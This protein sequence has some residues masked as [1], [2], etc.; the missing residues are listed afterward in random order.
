MAAGKSRSGAATNIQNLFSQGA[1]KRGNFA[2]KLIDENTETQLR[3][4]EQQIHRITLDLLLDNPYQPRETIAMDDELRELAESIKTHGFQGAI[5]ARK[6]PAR[7]GYYQLAY[8]HRRREAARLAGEPDLP[9]I[10]QNLSNRAMAGIAGIENIH[11]KDLTLLEQGKLFL[12]MQRE[13][14]TQQEIATMV[15]KDRG[16][17]VNRLRVA[18][19]PA[20]IQ[21]FVVAKPDSLRMVAYLMKVDEP[22]DRALL[23]DLIRAGKLK[24]DDLAGDINGLVASLSATR[25]VSSPPSALQ[26][27]Q[28]VTDESPVPSPAQRRAPSLLAP[29]PDAVSPQPGAA[30]TDAGKPAKDSVSHVLDAQREAR[31]G[32]RKL[33]AIA[34]SLNDYWKDAQRRQEISE[35]EQHLI[36]EILVSVEK[37]KTAMETSSL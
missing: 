37:M 1:L 26:P 10:V 35:Q 18:E 19:A 2:G 29:S 11:R 32:S 34:R 23:F 21:A 4:H 36:E 25:S 20:D 33:A 24:T 14:Y 9:I 8:G 5:P 12:H 16:Y 17:V 3:P 27:S 31:L 13:G 22:A 7:E 30:H 6:H 15:A 28:A